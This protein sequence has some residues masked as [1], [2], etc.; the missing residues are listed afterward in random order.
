MHHG[1]HWERDQVPHLNHAA[2]DPT[3]KAKHKAHQRKHGDKQ[4]A[5]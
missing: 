1:G 4:D 3:P 2:H 5:D